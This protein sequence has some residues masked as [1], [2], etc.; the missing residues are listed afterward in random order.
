MLVNRGIYPIV[1]LYKRLLEVFGVPDGEMDT[2]ESG[3]TAANY[4]NPSFTKR[5][6]GCHGYDVLA[7][8]ELV[9]MSANKKQRNLFSIEM[10]KL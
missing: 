2:H 3:N 10:E 4:S 6:E 9:S 7:G 8:K 5:G 1:N